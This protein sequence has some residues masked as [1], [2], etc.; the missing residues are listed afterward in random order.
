MKHTLAH[1]LYITQHFEPVSAY[2]S[3]TVLWLDPDLTTWPP[4]ERVSLVTWEKCLYSV[5]PT[6]GISKYY[7]LRVLHFQSQTVLF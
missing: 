4:G 5:W 7:G 6:S 1:W 3:L 2:H